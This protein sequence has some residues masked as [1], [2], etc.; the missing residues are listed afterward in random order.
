MDPPAAPAEFFDALGFDARPAGTIPVD[1][2]FSPQGCHAGVYPP[3][4][5]L[6][7]NNITLDLL[8]PSSPRWLILNER[9]PNRRMLAAMLVSGANAYGWVLFQAGRL[10]RAKAGSE[11]GISAESGPM[12]AE[13]KA[14]E[15]R[16]PDMTHDQLGEEMVFELMGPFLG[17]RPDTAECEPFFEHELTTFEVRRAGLLRR[18]FRRS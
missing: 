17:A 7:D 8:D 9:F 5:V 16:Q 18:L 15:A 4:F 1:E 12:L 10:V 14:I 11:M 13:E 6:F 2:C 3:S